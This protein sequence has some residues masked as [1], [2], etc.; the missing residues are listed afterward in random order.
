M[1][2]ISN[3]QLTKYTNV[4]YGLGELP[5]EN[6][7]QKSLPLLH[8]LLV[9]KQSL[10][11]SEFRILDLYLSR[12]DSHKP[13]NKTIIF[14]KEELKRIFEIDKI[15][16]YAIVKSLENLV[17]KAILYK[18]KKDDNTTLSLEHLKQIDINTRIN[19]KSEMIQIFNPPVLETKDGKVMITLECSKKAEPYIFNVENLKYIKYK[20]KNIIKLRSKYSYNLFM[21]LELQSFNTK[22]W[23]KERKW[24]VDIEQFK[25]ILGCEQLK[26]KSFAELNKNVIKLALEDVNDNTDRHFTYKYIK[27]NRNVSHIEF[28]LDSINEKYIEA[29]IDDGENE[30]YEIEYLLYK[31]RYSQEQLN[32]ILEI[33]EEIPQNILLD[34]IP[35]KEREKS[36]TLPYK[37]YI[38]VLK[39]FYVK[40]CYLKLL[41]QRDKRKIDNDFNYFLGILKR[42]K[43]K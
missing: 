22:Y 4:I 21:Y 42:E 17:T 24:I 23:N 16:L 29:E 2:K 9:L 27:V 7:V 31:E 12:I 37:E 1:E 3:T 15:N 19:L 28:T 38:E 36:K 30:K 35:D 32:K 8:S 39:Y 25:R 40:K 18:I 5:Q 43:E 33:V 26:Y 10:T 14:N 41:N 11:F 6:V 20:L 34:C 13:E